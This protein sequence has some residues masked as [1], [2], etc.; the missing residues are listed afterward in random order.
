MTR[1]ILIICF[2]ITL[3]CGALFFGGCGKVS[4]HD[5]VFVGRSGVDD[6]GAF[7]EVS[8]TISGAELKDCG[9]V[10]WHIDGTLKDEH[11]GKV[12]GE[13][14]NADYYAKAQLAVRAMDDYVRQYKETW[15]LNK[16]DGIS[17]ATIAYNQFIEAAEKALG[18]ARR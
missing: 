18:Q 2:I 10:T 9:F 14:S 11:Y 5:G 8:I 6:T 12:N 16:I 4:Y 17:G 15:N 7:G 1:K 13:I 3:F